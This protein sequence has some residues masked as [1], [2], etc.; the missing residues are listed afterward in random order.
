[1][2]TMHPTPTTKP[3]DSLPPAD[4]LVAALPPADSFELVDVPLPTLEAHE[5]SIPIRC[6]DLTRMLLAD[7][8]LAPSDRVRLGQLAKLLGAVFHYEFYDWLTELKEL[9][10]PI[11]PD[12]DCV[13]V[14]HCS[15]LADVGSNEAFLGPFETALV[16]ANY[17]PLARHVLEE[18]I[19]APNDLGLDY[20]PDL[21]LFSDLRVYVRGQGKVIRTLRN[22]HTYFRKKTVSYDAYRRV[23]IALRYRSDTE[24]D[25]YVRSDVLYLRMFKDVPFVEMDMH[26]PE[27]GTKI[28][29][30]WLDKLQIASPVFTGIP[31]VMAKLLLEATISPMLMAFILFAPISAGVRSFFGYRTAR[32]RYLHYMIR[33]LYYLTLANNASVINR[34]IDSAEEEEFKEA[35][36]AYFTLL[37]GRDDP[38]PWDQTRLDLAVEDLVRKQ[39]GCDLDFEVTDALNKLFRLGLA[40]RNAQGHLAAT[41][42]DQA[43]EV[44]D[45]RWDHYFNYPCQDRANLLQR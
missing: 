35:Y 45:Q 17:V 16:R 28:K 33:H 39:T 26:L 41:P 3:A 37:R 36:L 13:R 11:D 6:G 2:A 29:M 12:S 10:A 20:I 24:L 9:Y 8:A 32:R 25:E 18:A 14:S 34:L 15:A 21:K 42:L 43:L 4:E 40:H 5:R 44:L 22:V 19:S 1:M 31:A 7:P 30:R 38:Q 27:Q 23:V